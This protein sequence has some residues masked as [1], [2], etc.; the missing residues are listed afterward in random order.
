MSELRNNVCKDGIRTQLNLI[1]AMMRF[2]TTVLDMAPDNEMVCETLASMAQGVSEQADVLRRD[3][4]S[5][6]LALSEEG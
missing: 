5:Y 4:G 2:L 3:V 1:Y 6:I